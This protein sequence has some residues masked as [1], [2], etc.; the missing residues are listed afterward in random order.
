V[1]EAVRDGRFRPVTSI[2]SP[3]LPRVVKKLKTIPFQ[4]GHALI[5]VSELASRDQPS[6]AGAD[7]D[8]V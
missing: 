2:V 6:H 5:V 8:G 1:V 3:S 4:D 7:D